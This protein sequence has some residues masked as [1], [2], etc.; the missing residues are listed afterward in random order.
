MEVP[1]I[2]WVGFGCLT[3]KNWDPYLLSLLLIEVR[4]T[5]SVLGRHAAALHT[6]VVMNGCHGLEGIHGHH[7]KPPLCR[8]DK[9]LISWETGLCAI[10]GNVKYSWDPFFVRPSMHHIVITQTLSL[11][12]SNYVYCV[13]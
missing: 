6:S 2:L 4:A 12:C 1:F 8:V 13:V 5:L 9:N 7:V 11:A 10:Y 3:H